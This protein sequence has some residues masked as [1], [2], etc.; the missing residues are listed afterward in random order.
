MRIGLQAYPRFLELAYQLSRRL[1]LPFSRWMVPGGWIEKI[2][3]VLEKGAKGAIFDCRM[4]GDCV[5]HSTGMTCPMTC[6]KNMRNGPCGGVRQNGNCEI[7]PE[8]KCVWMQAWDRSKVMR[9]YGDDFLGILPPRK[10]QLQDGSAWI[11]DFTGI[12]VQDPASW[13]E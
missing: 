8:M 12:A 3:V 2:F 9:V 13:L 10:G 1:L 5:L 4:C 6:P 11:N 7:I